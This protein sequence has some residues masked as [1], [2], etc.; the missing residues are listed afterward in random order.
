MRDQAKNHNNCNEM[1]EQESDQ[2]EFC[3][4]C[5]LNHDQGRRHNC[6]AINHLAS[7]DH[8]KNL[9]SFLWKYSGGMHKVDSFRISETDLA[10]WKKKCTSLRSGA[11]SEG[12]HGPLIGPSNDIHNELNSECVDSFEKNTDHFLRSSFS[13]GVMPL[14]NYTN[15]RYQVSHSEPS[16]VT[17]VDPPVHDAKAYLAAGTQFDTNP[18]G[19]TNLAAYIESRRPLVCDGGRYLAS[20]SL[21]NGGLGIFL[22]SKYGSII[23][24]KLDSLIGGVERNFSK[25]N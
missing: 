10:K 22:D 7:A 18:Q 16:E 20:G 8:L 14:Q 12:S 24:A 25:G 21:C 13:N 5:R 6:N 11:S 4:V 2:F 17:E 23:L 1:T 19:L 9:K 3:H 15:E